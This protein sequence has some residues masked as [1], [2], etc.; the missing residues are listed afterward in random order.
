[1]VV[2]NVYPKYCIVLEV[3]LKTSCS[4]PNVVVL[5]T[6]QIMAVFQPEDLH[7]C[8]CSF[9]N[10]LYKCQYHPDPSVT[11]ISTCRTLPCIWWGSSWNSSI[12]VWKNAYSWAGIFEGDALALHTDGVNPFA[13]DKSDERRPPPKAKCIKKWCLTI[14]HM[15][16]L[17][18][19]MIITIGCM[20]ITILTTCIHRAQATLIAKSTGCKGSCCL[21]KLPAIMTDMSRLCQMLCTQLRILQKIIVDMYRAIKEV[22]FMLI[23]YI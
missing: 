17:K 13:P 21:M 22:R 15:I 20:N 9:Q 14:K 7:I 3:T 18:I 1:M 6:S 11:W 4:V 16:M 5:G 2:Y 8:H 10:D 19:G 12:C 23:L